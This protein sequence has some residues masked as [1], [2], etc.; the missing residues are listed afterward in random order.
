VKTVGVT[1]G[2]GS[3][4]STATRFLSELGAEVIDADQVGHYTYRPGSEGWRR[5]VDVFG[6]QV[7]AAD[8][9]ID[10]KRLGA[11]VFSDSDSLAR[12]NAIVHPLI[13]EEIRT[14]IR[15]RRAAGFEGPIVVEAA[16]L[17]EAGWLPLVDE[18]WLVVADRESVLDRVQAQRGLER[19]SIEAR[20]SAQT[21]DDERRRHATVVIDNSGSEAALRAEIER[22]WQE[23]LT[24]TRGG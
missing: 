5:I 17:I 4:K 16:V 3:G 1:G 10:R 24:E 23:R 6:P 8:G 7:V 19:S 21:S 14:R 12:L 9:T 13:H 11:V 18:V 2:I 15:A 22:L 20:M